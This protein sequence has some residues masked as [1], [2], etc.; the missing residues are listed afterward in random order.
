MYKNR[1]ATRAAIAPVIEGLRARGYTFVT[2]KQLL[3]ARS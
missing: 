3:A 2:V 1:A